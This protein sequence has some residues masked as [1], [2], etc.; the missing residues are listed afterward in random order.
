MSIWS[1][2]ANVFRGGHPGRAID[3]EFAAHI[4]EAINK[5]RDPEEARKAFGS[6]LRQREASLDIRLLGWL[7]SLRAD[8]VFGRRLLWNAKA[9]S[10]VAILSLGLATGSCMSA[11]RIIDALLLRPLPIREPDRLYAIFRKG[12]GPD[13]RPRTT[14]SS[15]Y[16]LYAQMRTAVENQADLIAISYAARRDLTYSSDEETEKAYVQYVSGSMFDK[17]GV[18]PALGRVFTENDD[19]KPGAHPV[20][21]LSYA[22]GRGASGATRPSSGA[23]FVSLPRTLRS[24][25]SPIARLREPSQGRSP[26]YSSRP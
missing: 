17:F 10:T 9:T 8:I 2:V 4:Q 24:S 22:I 16:P 19:F 20:A 1:R 26:R 25:A 23:G 7:D 6:V 11:F 18:R 5:G 13:G 15:E 21:V 3:E 12:I 14:A